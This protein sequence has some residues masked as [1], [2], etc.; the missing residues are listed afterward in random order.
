[1]GDLMKDMMIKSQT[2]SSKKTNKFSIKRN[3]APDEVPQK[4]PPRSIQTHT[5]T[6]F[7][8]LNFPW[9]LHLPK[10]HHRKDL[11]LDHL[12]STLCT[13]MVSFAKKRSGNC[14]DVCLGNLLLRRF[15]FYGFYYMGF[16]T[17]FHGPFGI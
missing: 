16:I 14:E 12:T 9:F 1:M 5:H 17:M 15:F 13:S 10:T 8:I 4:P 3:I 7:Y 2:T 6:V 11:W